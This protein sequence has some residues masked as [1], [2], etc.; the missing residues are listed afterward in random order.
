MY[1]I[2]QLVVYGSHGVCYIVQMEDRT[3]DRN[4]VSYYVLEPV[5]Q[6]GTRFL[7]PTH[8]QAALAKIRPLMEKEQLLSA[9][10]DTSARQDW[11][12]D[13]NRRKQQYRQILTS[14]DTLWQ[15]GMLRL[16]YI[17]KRKQQEAGRKI[18]Q[19]D[20]NFLRDVSKVLVSEMCAVLA[21]TEQEA[22]ACLQQ[23]LQDE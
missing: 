13:E 22:F 7:I 4:K 20:D 3:V 14:G 10:T 2:S 15:L 11:I 8:N 16:L 1:Q 23:Y 17:H 21:M 9:L 5:S 12:P 19:C 6:P 18:H